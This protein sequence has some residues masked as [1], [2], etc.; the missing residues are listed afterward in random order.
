MISFNASR[1]ANKR[2]K[3]ERVNL[4]HRMLKVSQKKSEESM[5]KEAASKC[6]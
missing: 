4:G 5:K 2:N 3:Q 6:F 1:N